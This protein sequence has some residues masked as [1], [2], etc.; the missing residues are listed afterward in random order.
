M[1]FPKSGQPLLN[2]MQC[3]EFEDRLNLVLDQRGNPA[4][5]SR[6]RAH[7]ARCDDCQQLLAGQAAL[8]AG[9][10]RTPVAEIPHDFA[11][12]IVHAAHSPELQPAPARQ[13][14]WLAIGL[15]LA[16]AATVLLAFSALWM[17]RSRSADQ[18]AITR[19]AAVWW[20]RSR[21]PAGNF[22]ML[23]P[24]T[25]LGTKRPAPSLGITGADLLIEVPRLSAHLWHYSGAIDDFVIALPDAALS[26]EEMEQLA[27]GIR[28]LRISLALIWDTLCRTIPGGRGEATSQPPE[29]TGGWRIEAPW[30]RL[31]CLPV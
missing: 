21:Q 24:G 6:L 25:R 2:A 10:E 30:G 22:A 15:G 19:P 17:S 26:L 13:R 12:R 7:A 29:Q 28:P 8:F 4:A 14:H 1:R 23:Q 31:S 11:L 3:H 16:T 27:P 20:K 9:L 5:D 18:L